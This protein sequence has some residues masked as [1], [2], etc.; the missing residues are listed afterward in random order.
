M[1]LYSFSIVLSFFF[2]LLSFYKDLVRCLF[3]THFLDKERQ[4]QEFCPGYHSLESGKTIKFIFYIILFSLAFPIVRYIF[5]LW[6]QS[7]GQD[8]QYLKVTQKL[9]HKG[10][11]KVSP[12]EVHFGLSL[13]LD[14]GG[15]SLWHN[16]FQK[17]SLGSSCRKQVTFLRSQLLC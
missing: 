7:I 8:K 10:T 3:I 16:L 11:M 4:A 13:S 2:F 9:A 1:V 6:Y 15:L 5:F 14:K 17:M 12:L